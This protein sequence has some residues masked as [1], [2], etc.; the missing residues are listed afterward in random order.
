MF[1]VVTN[2]EDLMKVFIVRGIV[3]IEEQGVPYTIERDEHDLSATHIL[4]EM[5]GE[6]LQQAAYGP[7]ESMR[8]WNV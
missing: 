8:S 3:F 1:Q 5:D 2:L 6:P 7:L 4:G